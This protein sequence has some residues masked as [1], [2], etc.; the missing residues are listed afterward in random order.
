M[1]LAN[2]RLMRSQT[3]GELSTLPRCGPVAMF[4]A[5]RDQDTYFWSSRSASLCRRRVYPK[6]IS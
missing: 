3:V 2:N 5:K 1:L 4:L 6:V